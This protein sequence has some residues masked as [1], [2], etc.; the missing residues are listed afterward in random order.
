MN[1]DNT[2]R[3]INTMDYSDK[4]V[5]FLMQVG[6]VSNYFDEKIR[7]DIKDKCLKVLETFMNKNEYT[8]IDDAVLISVPIQVVPDLLKMMINANIAVY[9]IIPL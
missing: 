6:G 4:K 2:V 9:S 5:R 8:F 7:I 1:N 3:K